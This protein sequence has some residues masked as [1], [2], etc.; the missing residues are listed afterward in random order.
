MRQQ[1]AEIAVLANFIHKRVLAVNPV[2]QYILPSFA[3]FT[4]KV[5][6]SMQ[7]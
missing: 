3:N 5:I 4:H 1:C 2:W 6:H 7:S